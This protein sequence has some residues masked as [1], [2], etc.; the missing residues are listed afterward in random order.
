MNDHKPLTL[1]DPATC[2]INTNSY[3]LNS[4]TYQ[5]G[6]GNDITPNPG[7]LTQLGRDIRSTRERISDVCDRSEDGKA[8]KRKLI[9]R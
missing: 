9:S 4:N 7:K 3:K 2:D 1:R 8:N 6:E 5:V